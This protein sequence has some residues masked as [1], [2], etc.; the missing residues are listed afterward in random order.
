[1]RSVFLRSIEMI[2]KKPAGFPFN[3]PVVRSLT[4]IESVDYDSLEHVVVTRDFL[5]NPASFLRILMA[6]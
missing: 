3:V 4:R 2:D 5:N 6:D 1:V